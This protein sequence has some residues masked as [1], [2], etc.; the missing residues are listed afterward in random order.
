MTDHDDGLARFVAA[1]DRAG[2]YEHALAELRRGRKQSHWIWYVFPQ[3][4]G[5]GH[6]DMSRHYALSSLAEARD[7]L[8]HPVLGPRLEEASRALLGVQG[9]SIQ[10][11]LGP[12]DAQKVHSSMTLFLRAGPMDAPYQQVLDVYFG[13][14][15]DAGTERLL[16]AR[17]HGG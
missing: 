11:I 4:D 17:P 5:L 6:S 1:Q 8:A 13:G 2:T 16:A 14:E 15:P 10:E 9:H 12:I 7:Y 3:L